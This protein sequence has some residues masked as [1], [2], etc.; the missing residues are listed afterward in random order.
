MNVSVAL[1]QEIVEQMKQIINQE[2]NYMNQKGVIIASTDPNR[3]GNFHGGAKTVIETNQKLIIDYDK[4]F[5]G[6]K[7][8]INVPVK[9]ENETIGVIGI[10]GEK[11]EV[12]KY[13]EIIKKMTEILIKENYLNTL[14]FRKR[15]QD[16]LL[17]ETL[18]QHKQWDEQTKIQLNLLDFDRSLNYTCVVGKP[19]SY[20]SNQEHVYHGLDHYFTHNQSCHYAVLQDTVYLLFKTNH[21]AT[22]TNELNKLNHFLFHELK[23]NYHFGI[24]PV[25]NLAVTIYQHFKQAEHALTWALVEA[26]SIVFYQDMDLGL[27][28]TTL[29]TEAKTAFVDKMLG[30]IPE[31]ER[32]KLKEIL[33]TYGANNK[34]I[35]KSCE[36]LFIH[37]NTC[38]YRLN[39][40]KDYTGY[41]P[42]DIN[43]Y[44]KLYL[45]FILD[46]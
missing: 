28:I 37:K 23:L 32:E 7:K 31:N 11:E 27:L 15:E 9:M 20:F 16:R 29:K 46:D 33:L 44:V 42:K 43:D 4:Q 2:V 35:T 3:I 26:Q 14:S 38:Q 25:E 17:I 40:L 5:T 19:S 10:T 21:A 12:E 41:D 6:T 39:K 18:R 22:V 45:A 30:A 1:A 13:G 36:T 8:G 24:S 34:S